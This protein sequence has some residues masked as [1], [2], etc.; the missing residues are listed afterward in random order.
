LARVVAPFLLGVALPIALFLVPYARSHA[1]GD[2]VHGVF[3][4]PTKRLGVTAVR[5]P[6]LWTS[7]ALLPLGAAV[8]LARRQP[9]RRAAALLIVA[10]VSLL[11]AGRFVAG[12]YRA[13]WYSARSLVPALVL[14]GVMVLSRRRMA[15][16]DAPLLRSRTMLLLS[17]TAL[18]SLV[19][20]PFASPIYF[21]Y[22]APLVA[23][24]AL[25]L[26]CHLRPAATTVPMAV[27]AFYLAFAMW[28]VNTSSLY[29]MGT[30]YRPYFRTERLTPAR[31]GGLEIPRVQAMGY[32]YVIPL[33]REHARGGYTWAS[34]D[35]PEIYFL[36]GL[37]NPTRSLFEFFE[38][39]TGHTER[40]LH[41]LDARGVTAIVMNRTPGFSPDISD[42]L[43]GAL[44]QRYPVAERVGNFLVRWTP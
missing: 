4:L 25:A 32:N 27:T 15:D 19:Q 16:E 23:L 37:R 7:L 36:S 41:A 9:T 3:V 8:L 1:V 21:C 2:F 42:E 29:G 34:P 43:A 11:V 6:P 33:L 20:F 22:V 12:P 44:A 28:L 14:A 30:V 39:S 26:V 40:V 24:S 5:M 10:L 17:V 38:D 18:C 31:G 35:C 13:M